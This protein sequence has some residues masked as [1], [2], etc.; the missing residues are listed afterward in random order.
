MSSLSQ[1]LAKFVIETK[2]DDLPEDVVH[3]GKRSLLDSI[4]SAIAGVTIDKGKIAVTVVK[5]L[6][7]PQESSII[8]VGDR[9]SCSNAAFANGELVNGL[10]YDAVPHIPPICTLIP[11]P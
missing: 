11:H 7:G 5:R 9:V 6:G 8:G 4:G 2:F 1:E 3:E 10:D